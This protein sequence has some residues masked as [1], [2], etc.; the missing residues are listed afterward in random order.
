MMA[1]K[2]KTDT[3]EVKG[4]HLTVTA[5]GQLKWDWDA[6]L[7][8]VRAATNIVIVTEAKVK[9]TRKPRAKKVKDET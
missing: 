8:E 7:D 1:R 6:L 3:V 2:K 4:N 9:K 5:D